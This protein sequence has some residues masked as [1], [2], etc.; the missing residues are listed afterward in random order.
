MFEIDEKTLIEES[1]KHFEEFLLREKRSLSTF[2][3]D[4][5][6]EYVA[7]ECLEKF[8]FKPAQG[9]LFLPLASFLE[10]ELD[11]N[12]I[13]FHIYYELALYPD[14]K[15]NTK[16][17]LN[18]REDWRKEIEHMTEYILSIV[19]KK[20]LE[21]FYNDKII[22]QYVEREILDFLYS[23][24]KY[25][26]FLRVLQ[27]CPIYREEENFVKVI[28]YMKSIGKNR[29]SLFEMGNHKV[30]INTFLYIEL[31][32][33][34]VELK[35]EVKEEFENKIFN[36]DIYS[37][38]RGELIRQIN[39]GDGIERRD[40]LVRSFIYPIYRK[41]WEGEI[42]KMS[43]SRKGMEDLEGQEFKGE[44]VK[45]ELESS[46]EE[47]RTILK[48]MEELQKNSKTQNLGQSNLKEYGISKLDFLTFKYYSDL[49][50]TERELMKEFWRK[51]IGSA[52][53]EVNVEVREQIRGKLDV[54]SLIK[55]Y[56][57]FIEAEKKGSYK[58]LKLFNRY[59][60]SDEN[61]ILPEKIEI[62]FV[63]DNSGSMNE[64]KIEEARKALAVTL[65]S[66]DDF[67]N[68]LKANSNKLN[69][70]IEAL[71]ETYFFGSDCHKVKNFNS[72]SKEK[73]ES[74]II[75]SIVRLNGEDGSTD[76]ANCLREISDSI[77]S[78][79]ERKLKKGKLIK[80][81]FEI[82]DGAS[83]F[84]GATR[85]VIDELLN[86]NVEVYGFQ[87]GETNERSRKVFNYVW[88]ENYSKPRGIIL[89]EN[90]GKLPRELLKAVSKNMSEIFIG[91][92]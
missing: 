6:L 91:S 83:S 72:S 20:N 52:R 15:N 45:G 21:E 77:T 38:L 13:L 55:Y 10:R 60:L 8:V 42:S 56:P 47:V 68:Y 23:F 86:K 66:I 29:D 53:R 69:Q 31:Y 81:I 30:F 9:I 33:M 36:R 62:S 14:W 41:L 22:Y 92:R 24:D 82:T 51:L 44:R 65:L 61:K 19:K 25:Y 40:D 4:S 85:E 12:E 78:L 35:E 18:R 27:L 34:G 26:S 84:P 89:G 7:D 76:D 70:K 32:G 43:F 80:I 28:S 74:E 3:G 49:M 63:I 39:K 88:N 57:D 2:T 5:N 48:E 17:Y 71:S 64:E 16:K 90:V 58:N 50:S 73:E 59:L 87:I 46:Q 79:E 67:N 75:K 1:K 54:D 11:D 37:F